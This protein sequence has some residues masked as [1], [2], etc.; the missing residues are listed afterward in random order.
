MID[1]LSYEQ[2]TEMINAFREQ[3]QII[4]KLSKGRKVPEI[5]DF[6]ESV[7][8]YCKFLENTIELNKD[9]DEALKNLVK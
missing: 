3:K 4:A 1:K 9:A 6:L 8:T 5:S 7:E 2:V